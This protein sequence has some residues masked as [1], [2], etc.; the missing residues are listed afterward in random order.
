MAP[1]SNYNSRPATVWNHGRL[2]E[3]FKPRPPRSFL[4]FPFLCCPLPEPFSFRSSLLLHLRDSHCRSYR[5]QKTTANAR[6]PVQ[7]THRHAINSVTRSLESLVASSG[8]ESGEHTRFNN[9]YCRTTWL[10]EKWY[11]SLG[12]ST[13]INYWWSLDN[14]PPENFQRQMIRCK[15]VFINNKETKKIEKRIQQFFPR[16]GK[17]KILC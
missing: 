5:E 17:M 16:F 8:L 2:V 7:R 4:S 14:E 15:Q 13:K 3:N 1:I 6:L 10:E 9:T 11:P 12:R